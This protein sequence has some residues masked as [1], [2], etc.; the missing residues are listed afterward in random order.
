MK[1]FWLI[2]RKIRKLVFT[3]DN[4]TPNY[5]LVHIEGSPKNKD[6][7]ITY[8]V[9][10]KMTTATVEP[11]KLVDDLMVLKGFTK[12][13]SDI[14]HGL[15]LGTKESPNYK[16]V[17]IL[18]EESGV[19]LSIY[20]LKNNFEFAMKAIEVVKDNRLLKSLPDNSIQMILALCS[21]ELRKF[22][23]ERVE[24]LSDKNSIPMRVVK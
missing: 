20:D 14:I 6:V 7:H 17:R 5:K 3:S 22:H 21:S 4:D 24:S 13:D 1:V 8:Q 16:I 11:G 12:E 15:A 10:G 19:L 9:C 23:C 18:F 2:K